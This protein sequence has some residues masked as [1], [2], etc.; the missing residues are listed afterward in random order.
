[1]S[2]VADFKL[3]VIILTGI[4]VSGALWFFGFGAFASALLVL[5]AVLGSYDL[6][7][8]IIGSLL[9]KQFALDYIAALAIAASLISQEFLVSAVIAL[10][11]SGGKNLEEYGVARAQRSLRQLADRIPGE[12]LLWEAGKPSQKQKIGDI[13]PGQ[14]ILAR[15]GEVL[16][17]D[18]VLVSPEALFDEASLT[19]EP[20]P[21]EKVKGDAVKSGT[22]NVG[23]A[24]VV[25]VSRAEKDSVY[26][27]IVAMVRKAQEEKAP[28]VRLAD[29]YSVAFTVISLAIAGIAFI[30]SQDFSRVL[31]VLV[32][33][34]PCPLLLATPIALLGGMNAG[35]KKRI[36]IKKLA[37]LEALSR[38][39][40]IIF[41]K[42]GTLTLGK[43]RVTLFRNVSLI[44]DIDCLSIAE[45]IERSSLH[46]LAKAVVAFARERQAPVLYA[47]A[48]QE[49]IGY[50][51][52]GVVNG[53]EYAMRKAPGQEGM[54][55]GLYRGDT[56]LCVFSFEDQVKAGAKDIV[57]LLD[58]QGTE[59][60]LC[61]GDKKEAARKIAE[62][63]GVKNVCVRAECTPEDKQ[64][65]IRSL[66]AEGKTVVMVGDGINDAPA[67]ALANVGMV[68]AAEE[69]TAASSAA[70][71]V[72]LGGDFSLV[73]E[74]FAIAKRAVSV[75]MRSIVF[76]ISASVIAMVFAA[77]GFVAPVAGAFL[78]EAI[79]VAVILYALRASR[80]V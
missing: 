43:P 2:I 67:L 4:L 23:D 66:Q 35:A 19:G 20:Y 60:Y 55:I 36:I 1:M 65:S 34:T 53:A 27:K 17:L 75:A 12:V 42:T 57:E 38:A 61:T 46:P 64:E 54:A 58:S 26:E 73:M 68:F 16:G 40:A 74:S 39:N 25:R 30:I 10:M 59:L 21:A 33:A 11:I 3:P 13:V 7:R 77:F 78:Q 56:L 31:A 80:G 44:S 62:H 70:D 5:V 72:F 29:K 22:V 79:D 32:V 18:G 52:S 71:I 48:V 41:D 50:G 51:I 63:I 37:A 47:D 15:K 28:L 8:E 24:V 49:K 6:F 69:Q 9:K 45:S 14:E 76:G